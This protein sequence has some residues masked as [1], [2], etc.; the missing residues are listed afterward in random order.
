MSM[1]A[2][3]TIGSYRGGIIPVKYKRVP[4]SPKNGGVRFTI[5][6]DNENYNFVVISNVGGAGSLLSVDVKGSGEWMKMTRNWGQEWQTNDGK[7]PANTALSFRITTTD[8]ENLE[9]TNAVPDN[10]KASSTKTF[11]TLIQF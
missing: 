7:L 3:L 10:W 1:P 11:P 2:W 4:C 8:G 6:G 5:T 9:F